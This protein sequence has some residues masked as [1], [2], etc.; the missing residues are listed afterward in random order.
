MKQEAGGEQKLVKASHP[1]RVREILS[2]TSGLRFRSAAQPGALDLMT[3][4]D[5]VRSFA[6]EPLVYQPGTDYLYSNEG[7]NTAA[8]II[9]VVSGMP[10]E[11]FMQERLFNPLG[12]KDTTFWPDGEQIGRLAGSY[13]LDAE[14][15]GLVEMPIDQLTYPLD[16]RQHRFPM[17]AGGLF[18]TASDLEKFCQMILNG[19]SLDGKRYI[20]A[21]SLHA[22]T[23][24]E[25][26]G[27]GKTDY[28]FG[29]TIGARGFG[30]GG[31]YKNAIDIDTTTGR[32]LVFMVQQAGAWGTADGDAMLPRLKELANTMVAG[33]GPH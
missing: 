33:Q 27:L 5:Q 13:K 9:E 28:G 16:D 23:S 21:A 22:M 24:S 32:I 4:K 26:R 19:G 20:S 10:Y 31:A 30:H 8:R 25:N 11:Q 3:L 1:I 15:K 18:S 6:A 29:W 7:L 12:M 2:H 14:S 17:P